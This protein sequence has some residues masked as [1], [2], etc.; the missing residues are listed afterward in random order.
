MDHTPPGGRGWESSVNVMPDLALAMK[1]NPKMKVTGIQSL[2]KAIPNDWTSWTWR[3][4]SL[5][6][7]LIYESH[8]VPSC[9][10]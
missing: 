3:R 1:R 7:S 2:A 10:V 4:V 6:P 9:I 5:N 8:Q